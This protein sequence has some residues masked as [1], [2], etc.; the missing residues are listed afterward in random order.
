[1]KIF[2]EDFSVF[3]SSFNDCLSNL[4]KMMKRHNLTLNWKKCHFH[5]LKKG[6]VLGYVIFKDEIKVDKT[7]TDLNVTLPPS[8]CVKEVKLFSWIC[9]LL[10]PNH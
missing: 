10:L 6:I 8:T 1:M 9:W 5:D 7:K 3:G 4:S 2:M